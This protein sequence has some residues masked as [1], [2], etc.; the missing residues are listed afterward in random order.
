MRK[1]IHYEP[2]VEKE[3]TTLSEKLNRGIRLMGWTEKEALKCL[4]KMDN[5]PDYYDRILQRT[6]T[7]YYLEEREAYQEKATSI[8]LEAL[9]LQI[10]SDLTE[11]SEQLAVSEANGSLAT[12]LAEI[13]YDQIKKYR[14]LY[15]RLSAEDALQF[16]DII[17]YSHLALQQEIERTLETFEN[18]ETAE[19]RERFLRNTSL[20]K[21]SNLLAD[22]D[23]Y[24]DDQNT[25]ISQKR[26]YHDR[27]QNF[28]QQTLI[29][30]K[31]DINFLIDQD[32]NNCLEVALQ[33]FS[34]KEIEMIETN[35]PY[36]ANLET[37][38]CFRNTAT[39]AKRIL[40][41]KIRELTKQL[42]LSAG[43]KK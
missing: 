7:I 42:K 10:I 2:E 13:G 4:S 38:L 24:D 39:K 17:K 30:S 18:V 14:K 27:L 5:W 20:S 6:K 19:E 40:S 22:L 32:E 29:Q 26:N 8:L 16:Q 36:V 35:S 34:I 23:K 11:I 25:A 1:E 28:R 21:L 33:N 37:Y 31:K 41:A 15:E 12:S 43:N 9:R 3:I